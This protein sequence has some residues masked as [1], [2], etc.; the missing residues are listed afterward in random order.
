MFADIAPSLCA[1]CQNVAV[2]CSFA[3][4]LTS[5]MQVL[6]V[7]S[8]CLNMCNVVVCMIVVFMPKKHKYYLH[9]VHSITCMMTAAILQVKPRGYCA[10]VEPV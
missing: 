1:A 9:I 2:A 6:S 7:K 4:T 5:H 3:E 10:C 8:H